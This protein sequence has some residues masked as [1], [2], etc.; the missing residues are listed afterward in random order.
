M[1][2]TVDNLR[3][4]EG[5]ARA[6]AR[7]TAQ[8]GL[9]RFA[10]VGLAVDAAQRV[11]DE[12]RLHVAWDRVGEGW[13]RLRRAP[14]GPDE[15][16][17][18]R[19][20]VVF[21][22]QRL[23]RPFRFLVAKVAAAV[24]GTYLE[25][26]LASFGRQVASEGAPRQS[27]TINSWGGDDGWRTFLCDHAMERKQFETFRFDGPSSTIT[28]G[29]IE[30]RFIT[31]RSRFDLPRFFNYAEPLEGD[32][33][34]SDA[35]TDLGDLD[36]IGGGQDKLEAMVRAEVA[37]VGDSGPVF[38]NSTC[39]PVIIGD[40]VDLVMSG[41]RAGCAQGL[42]HVSARNVDT[43]EVLIRFLDQARERASAAGRVGVRRG[44]VG[45]VGFPESAGLGDLVALLETAGIPVAGTIL[46]DTSETRMARVLEA[47]V[48]VCNP[49][50]HRN[51]MAD[52]VFRDV[53]LPRIAPSPPWGITGT[54]GWLLS[55]A[56]AVGRAAEA[57]PLVDAMRRRVLDDVAAVD[58]ARSLLGFVI[59]P[60]QEERLLSA[61][62]ATGLP[63]VPTLRDLGYPVRVAVWAGD[64]AAFRDARDRLADALG[65][66]DVGIVDFADPAGLDRALDGVRA[67]FSEYF[68]DARLTR[69]GIAQFAARDFRMGFAGALWTLGR[70]AD[71]AAL[72]FYRRYAGHLG[73]PVAQG[74]WR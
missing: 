6:L 66:P 47:E 41:C 9:D 50:V 2:G 70:L 3:F 54:A 12:V 19:V 73:G 13:L 37:R 45:L 59:E 11:G 68:Y 64:P 35:F 65:D 23:E 18:R 22:G 21:E 48:L 56:D 69:R 38:V 1:P 62:S 63:V 46:P 60:G 10:G 7:L 34:T 57:A 26:L 55:V 4:Q 40:D 71:V 32:S 14:A 8:C 29:D 74:W 44:A 5:D 58:R 20:A 17:P 67:V 72:P 28:H 49:G 61:D 16:A 39:V 33:D 27:T 51:R 15:A 25:D 30:C 52:R 24:A 31:P 42:F 43:V 36:V 53:A